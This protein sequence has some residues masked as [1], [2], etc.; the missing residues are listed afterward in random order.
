MIKDVM[1]L[2]THTIA[3][4]HAY[5]TIYEMARSAADKGLALLGIADHGPGMP[6]AV[7]KNYFNNVR[8]LPRE[9]YGVKTMFGCEVNI[10]DYSG[11]ID[12]EEKALG[13]IDFAVASFHKPCFKA[14]TITQNTQAYL[15]AMENPYVQ[16]IGHPDESDF[17]VDYE[18][19]VCAAKEHHVLL[20]V[21][22]ESFHP[23]CARKNCRDNYLKM[24]ELCK[25]YQVSV[26]IDSD[27]HCEADVGNHG[28]A[29]ELL[30]EIDFPKTLIANR[31]L[32]AAAEFIPF[33][34]RM[35]AGE[36]TLMDAAL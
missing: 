1:D 13:R 27:A 12:L 29:L 32:E 5:N 23:R 26:I 17:P 9:L 30:D 18:T 25:K 6:I 24:L 10:L 7:P 19:L 28:R 22:S 33:L 2:H 4:G 8:M 31:S 11:N 36:L 21:N 14:G 15:G 16:I 3:S 20:E 34:K 35:L